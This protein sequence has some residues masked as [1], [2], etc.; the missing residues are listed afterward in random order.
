MKCFSVDVEDYFQVCSPSSPVIKREQWP[1][2]ELRVR[3]NVELI[4]DL[5]DETPGTGDVLHPWP[6]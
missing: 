3:R 2:Y 1:R 6:G 5:M 4:L